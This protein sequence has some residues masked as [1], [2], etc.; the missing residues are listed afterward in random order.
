MT[1]TFEIDP[2]VFEEN[3]EHEGD[4]KLFAVFYHGTEVNQAKSLEAGRPVHDDI[5]LVKIIVPGQKDS[6]VAKATHEYQARF[7]KQWAQFQAKADQIGSGTPLTELSWLTMAQVADMKAM[8][9][10]TVEQMAGMADS[11]AHAFMG[12]HGMR[13]RARTYLEAA[14]GQAPLLKL[15]AELDALKAQN[16]EM[17]A[18]LKQVEAN[19]KLAKA[20]K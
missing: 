19:Q 6:V 11:S 10:H 2:Q 7:P 9:I 12:F 8:N 5:A 13:D 18:L 20:V 4:N 16:A 3:R 17:A 15:Q 1:P 14:A